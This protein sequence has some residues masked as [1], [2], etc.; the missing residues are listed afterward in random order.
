MKMNKFVVGLI[1]WALLP[2][3]MAFVS[4]LFWFTAN[5][6][7]PFNFK[8]TWKRNMIATIFVFIFMTYPSITV[9]TF[10]MF[11]CIEIENVKYL[12]R[13]FNLICYSDEHLK[14]L[15]F[16]G[17][18]VIMVWI[19]GFPLFIFVILLKNKKNLDNKDNIIKYGMFY[20]G[21]TDESF[22]WEI[23]VLNIRKVLF[24]VISVSMSPDNRIMQVLL[25]F[26][27][28]YLNHMLTKKI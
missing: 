14:A 16:V 5:L 26:T 1:L 23:I 8:R 15:V 18:P 9:S 21:L 12:K 17:I 20:V 6:F 28:L 25:C 27:C 24:I 19:L 3:G 10:E 22:Y 11:S 4:F 13:D 2:F 7:A